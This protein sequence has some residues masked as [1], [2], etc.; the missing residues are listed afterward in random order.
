MVATSKLIGTLF[1]LV[2]V[3]VGTPLITRQDQLLSTPANLTLDVVSHS[4]R[5]APAVELRGDGLYIAVTYNN[6]VASTDVSGRSND[7]F[8]TVKLKVGYPEGYF[9]EIHDPRFQAN[10]SLAERAVAEFTLYTSFGEAAASTS[11]V[12][13]FPGIRYSPSAAC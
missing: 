3:V 1:C 6:L 12:S 9:F 2:S 11:T 10:V 4:D 8:S 7:R 13:L 5:V